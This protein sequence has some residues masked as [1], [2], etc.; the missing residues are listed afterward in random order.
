MRILLRTT[1]KAKANQFLVDYIGHECAETFG[2]PE[3]TK[4]GITYQVCSWEMT[5]GQAEIISA[6]ILQGVFE[7]VDNF[8][9]YDQ[10]D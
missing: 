7:Q 5:D 1:T 8:D 9:D 2:Q 3:L 4:D 6:G 10:R